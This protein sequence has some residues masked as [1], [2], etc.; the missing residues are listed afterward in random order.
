MNKRRALSP[1][2]VCWLNCVSAAIPGIRE[3]WLI[4]SRA[5]GTERVDSDYDFLVFAEE[6]FWSTI[7][8]RGD[9]HRTDVDFLVSTDGNNFQSAWGCKKTV[10]LSK[11]NW[12]LTSDTTATYEGQKWIVDAHDP[13]EEAP[14]DTSS[15]GNI[16]HIQCIGV[17]VNIGAA[18]VSTIR[19]SRMCWLDGSSALTSQQGQ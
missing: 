9:L 19:D 1:T 6:K 2:I 16:Q 5:I 4:G 7:Q 13:D 11:L 8:E 12:K 18:I 17:K 15:L 14:Y 10:A 3:I